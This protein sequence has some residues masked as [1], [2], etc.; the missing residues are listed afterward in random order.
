MQHMQAGKWMRWVANVR[1]K[2]EIHSTYVCKDFSLHPV[3]MWHDVRCLWAGTIQ[4]W[5]PDG[6]QL[7]DGTQ[8]KADLVVQALGYDKPHAYLSAL[9]F[10]S[11]EIGEDGVHLYRNI[12][13]PNVPV[14]PGPFG[15]C[16][17]S[18]ALSYSSGIAKL[19]ELPAR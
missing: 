1:S 4:Q 10:K 3:Q 14:C 19:L 9:L 17:A 16:R 7:E 12:A 13:A 15:R 11:L 18:R 5:T 6:L 8:V 2:A